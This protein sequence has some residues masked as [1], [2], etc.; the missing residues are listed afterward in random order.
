MEKDCVWCKQT[1][2]SKH[3]ASYCSDTCRSRSRGAEYRGN[4]KL[5]MWRDGDAC[6][7]CFT[8]QSLEC[9]H[10]IHLAKG[11]S[12]SVDNLTVLCRIHHLEAHGKKSRKQE[13]II[14]HKQGQEISKGS[15]YYVIAS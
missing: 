5:A 1:F 6:T 11:G 14:E 12:N 9:H 4:R 8:N 15:D 3:G 13:V 2:I 7:V 10:I